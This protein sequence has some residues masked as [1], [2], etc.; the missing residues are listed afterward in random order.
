[1][2]L[3]YWLPFNPIFRLVF[4]EIKSKLNSLGLTNFILPKPLEPAVTIFP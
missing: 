4:G 3:F 2:K 1:M